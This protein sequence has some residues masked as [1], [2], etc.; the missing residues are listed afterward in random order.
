MPAV[1]CNDNTFLS[2]DKIENHGATTARRQQKVT[3]K[4]NTNTIII[5]IMLDKIYMHTLMYNYA[6]QK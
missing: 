5:K 4:T 3:D 2:I 6:H 1:Q